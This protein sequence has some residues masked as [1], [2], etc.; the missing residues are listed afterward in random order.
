MG[1]CF[2]FKIPKDEVALSLAAIADI[3][4]PLVWQSREHEVNFEESENK[5]CFN[6]F[7]FHQNTLKSQSGTLRKVPSNAQL[8]NFDS[9][10]FWISICQRS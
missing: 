2:G 7:N 1:N 8:P 4:E 5:S 3:A 6:F 9:P 10:K